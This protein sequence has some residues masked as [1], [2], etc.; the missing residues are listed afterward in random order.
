MD[1]FVIRLWN[2]VG[3][4][5]AITALVLLVGLV[6]GIVIAN[7]PTQHKASADPVRAA[8]A[9]ALP[10]VS[11]APPSS[12]QAD[13]QSKAQDAAAA[14][15]AQAK[16]ADDAARK[17]AEE[18]A[19]RSKTRS[20]TPSSVPATKYPVPAS[21]TVY[22]NVN[23]QKGCAQLLAI[24]FALDQ[25]PCLEKLWDKES[26]WNP[27]AHNKSSGAHGIP[28]ALPGSK[29]ASAGPNWYDNADTQIKWGL[30]YVKGKYKTPCGAWSYWQ[31]NHSY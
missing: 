17:K 1:T 30:G 26:G 11:S 15:A 24:G 29:M 22:T 14:A 10:S 2:R 5:R 19:S 20:A 27:L 8:D 13:A 18:E 23:K 31:A 6:G 7:R 3:K 9:A 25:M 4:V 16:A 21:C 12:E 28:Q